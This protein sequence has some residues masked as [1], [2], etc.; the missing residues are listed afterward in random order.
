MKGFQPGNKIGAKGRPK[1]I[2]SQVKDWIQEHPYAVAELMQALYEAGIE[3]DT[4][5]AKYVIDRIKGKPTA[6]TDITS[7]GEA[8][9]VGVVTRINELMAVRRREL[10]IGYKMLSGGED[11]T[12][13]EEDAS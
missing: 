1:K 9:G 10:G 7:D 6:H 4:E 11:A 12:I 3:G 13:K 5:S 8:L 2:K